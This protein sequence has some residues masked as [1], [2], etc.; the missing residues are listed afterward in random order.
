[1]DKI[2]I[3]TGFQSGFSLAEVLA[4][5]TI[6]AMILVAVLSI[7]NRAEKSAEAIERTFA[8]RRLPA[9]VLQR[10]AEDLDGII[11]E[12]KSTQITVKNKF[13]SHGYQMARLEILKT[14]YGDDKKPQVF[15]KIIWQSSYDYDSEIEGLVLYRSHSGMALED[16]LL[17]EEKENWER[18]LFVPVCE[19][20]TF[21]KIEVPRGDEFVDSWSTSTLPKGI[22]VTISFA[23]P[24]KTLSNTL[25]VPEEEKALRSIAIDK[26]RK[27]EFKIAS[28]K[29]DKEPDKKE[30]DDENTDSK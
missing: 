15:D 23:E 16:K 8:R 21:F 22:V 9:E 3:K 24:F 4:A 11:S 2:N 5:L 17:D 10:I 30:L 1:M 6:G 20:V 7:Y 28:I 19:G 29:S 12:A 25:D 13:D 14:I 26:S 27:I 18:E